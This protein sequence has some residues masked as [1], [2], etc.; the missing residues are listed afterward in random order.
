M[1][2]SETNYGRHCGAGHSWS[3][4]LWQRFEIADLRRLRSFGASSLSG[5]STSP[6]SMA[7]LRP[8]DA[9]NLVQLALRLRYDGE[10]LSDRLRRNP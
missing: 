1:P 4:M 6:N 3:L 5:Q 2:K 10:C 9:K 7:F 8:L